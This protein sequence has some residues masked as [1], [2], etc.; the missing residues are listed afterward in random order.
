MFLGAPL[1][2][3][4]LNYGKDSMYAKSMPGPMKYKNLRH[5]PLNHR[6]IKLVYMIKYQIFIFQFNDLKTGKNGFELWC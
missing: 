3:T 2:Y 6:D 1:P 5:N 4:A